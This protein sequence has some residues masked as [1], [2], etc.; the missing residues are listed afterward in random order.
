MRAII[1]KFMPRFIKQLAKRILGF[2]YWDPW[3]TPSW[4]QEGEDMVLRRIFEK[5]RKGVYVDVGAHHPKRFSN[6]YFFYKQG[7]SGINI[8]AMPKSMVAFNKKRPRD[9]NIESGVGLTHGVMEYYVFNESAL[10]GFCAELSKNR[11]DCNNSY[12]VKEIVSVDVLPLGEILDNHLQDTNID[13]MSID[14]EGLDLEVLKS[15][16]WKKYRPSIVLVEIL[17]SSLHELKNNVI[18]KYMDENGYAL[19]AKQVNTVFFTDIECVSEN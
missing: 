11:N 7:W 19:Y 17:N 4:S 1:R 14:V 9:I 5:Q 8:D 15:N 10:N 3:F 18:V 6:T 16:D 2:L 12:F 13:F